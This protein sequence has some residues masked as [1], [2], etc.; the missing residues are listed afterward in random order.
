MPYQFMYTQ[1]L[2]QYQLLETTFHNQSKE[3]LEL[4]SELE[5]LMQER[6][7]LLQEEVPTQATLP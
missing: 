6:I 1:L 2:A 7:S 3:N 4:Y 5:K